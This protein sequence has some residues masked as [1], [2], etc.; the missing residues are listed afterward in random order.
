MHY[1]ESIKAI[2]NEVSRPSDVYHR[3]LV[4]PWHFQVDI[5][6]P[7]N[8]LHP[9]WTSAGAHMGATSHHVGSRLEFLFNLRWG[10]IFFEGH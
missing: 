7:T 6:Q 5:H 1:G 8:S 3:S 2:G 4:A 9:L 10:H